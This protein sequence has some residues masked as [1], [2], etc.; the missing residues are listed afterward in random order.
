[1]VADWRH[2]DSRIMIWDLD[3]EFGLLGET[4]PVQLSYGATHHIDAVKAEFDQ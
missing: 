3:E 2:I 4:E 1:M